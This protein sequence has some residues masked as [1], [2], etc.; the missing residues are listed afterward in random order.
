MNTRICGLCGKEKSLEEYQRNKSNPL[1]RAY[2][3]K[4]CRRDFDRQRNLR[5][6]RKLYIKQWETSER[7]R[8]LRAISRKADR[9]A[10]KEKYQARRILNKL[11]KEGLIR[12]MP[13]VKCGETNSN[14]HHPDY[15]H[16][17]GVIWLCP[18][19][20]AEVHRLTIE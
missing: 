15:S 18:K 20:H 2:W 7:G 10:N 11:V 6:D 19:H 3:C 1:G 12:K 9:E 14:G 5:P 8:A 4:E 17:V 13:C 16:A